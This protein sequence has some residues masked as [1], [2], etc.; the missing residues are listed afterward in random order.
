MD[1]EELKR[2]S[3]KPLIFHDN[4]IERLYKGGRL[5]NAWQGLETIEPTTWAEEYLV[6]TTKYIGPA[7]NVTDGISRYEM[8]DG[9]LVKLNDL[10]ASDKEAFLGK[11]FKDMEG[12]HSWIE[13]RAG[14]SDCRLVLQCHPAKE[15]AK[16][17]FGMPCGKTEAWYVLDCEDSNG[18]KPHLYAGFKEGV[19]KERWIDLIEREDTEGL[20]NC[21]HKIYVNRGDCVIIPASMPHGMGSGICF[22]EIHEPCDLTFRAERSYSVKRL[23]D[24]EMHLGIGYEAMYNSYM[25]K[26]FSDDEIL[27]TVYMEKK[28][29]DETGGAVMTALVTDDKSDV[30]R[31]HKLEIAS[32]SYTIPHIHTHFILIAAKG[33][34][35]LK[36][37]GYEVTL[38]QGRGAFIPAAIESLTIVGEKAEMILSYPGKI[39]DSKENDYTKEPLITELNRVMRLFEGGK[40]LDEWQGL[41]NPADN[42][43]T[44]EMLVSTIEY[45]GPQ[46]E[47]WEHGIS[48]VKMADGTRVS[49]KALIDAK[50]EEMLGAQYVERYD[51]HSGVIV[52]AGDSAKER[53]VLQMHPN[54][55]DAQKFLNMKSG[56]TEVKYIIATRD[57]VNLNPFMYCGFKKGVTK[58][59]WMEAYNAQ[60]IPRM[61]SY[62][63]KIFLQKGDVVVISGAMPHA[64]GAGCTY[65]EISQPCEYIF[66]TERMVGGKILDDDAMHN[67]LGYDIMFNMFDYTTYTEE[68][69]EAKI[70]I[71]RS[72]AMEEEGGILYDI[73]SYKDTN[74]L[75]SGQM[76]DLN[77]RAIMKLP[78]FEGHL[79][80]VGIEGDTTVYYEGG[81]KT[82]LQGRGAFVPAKVKGLSLKGASKVIICYPFKRK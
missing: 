2:I 69:I 17:Y 27:N 44:E 24:R 26:T 80:L 36:A 57:D 25:Y 77:D 47:L 73:Y 68:E 3:K 40:A 66:R 53:L 59:M 30:M 54:D 13:A 15:V 72:I 34:A 51:G 46:K 33:D 7:D 52:R 58:Q 60:D 42:N 48:P 41:E 4:R 43:M 20:L 45:R 56:K 1:R 79:L 22:L 37:N 31:I 18:E 81:E 10:I 19:T 38:R 63:H 70:H 76:A 61:E 67:G 9:T 82:L 11:Q 8:E 16:K 5:L 32:G 55:E 49:L 50:P 12:N 75:L 6:M 65:L 28:V 21:L 62:L 23:S 74:D 39:Y 29:M 35:V 64:M 78:K 71:K 14:D